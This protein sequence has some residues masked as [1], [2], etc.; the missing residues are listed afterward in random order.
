MSEL[1]EGFDFLTG[2]KN[3]IT[4]LGTKSTPSKSEYYDAA[5]SMG[6]YFAESDYAVV[7]GGGPGIMEAAS[8]GAYE[9][10]GESIGVNMRV[11]GVERRNKFLTSSVSF[12][13]PFVRKLIITAPSNG[14]VFFPG[15]FGTLHQLFELLTLVE[16]GKI[17][18][19]PLCLYDS[20]FWSPLGDFINKMFFDFHTISTGDRNLC[21]IVENTEEVFN[22]IDSK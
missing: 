14:F 22:C 5:L 4:I 9:I 17:K 2:L 7:T 19:I 6:R 10:G 20:K 8:R 21:K 11:K 16:T 12:T 1:V 15:G 3:N 13:F 18:P